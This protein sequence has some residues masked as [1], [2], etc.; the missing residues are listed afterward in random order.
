MLAERVQSN[1]LI[2]ILYPIENTSFLKQPLGCTNDYTCTSLP[3]RNAEIERFDADQAFV[4]V[5]NQEDPEPAVS[6]R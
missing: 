1:F 2:F 5:K 3:A 4:T 6:Q